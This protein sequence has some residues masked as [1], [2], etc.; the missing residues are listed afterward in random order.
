M[1]QASS[2]QPIRFEGE[3]V[4]IDIKGW[5]RPHKA[6]GDRV[7]IYTAA[8]RRA[9]AGWRATSPMASSATRCAPCGGSTT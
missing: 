4:D 5:I 1:E 8:I 2:G 9:C 7:P 6:A 3:Y